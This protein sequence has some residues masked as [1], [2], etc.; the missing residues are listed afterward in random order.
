M[1]SQYISIDPAIRSGEP[2]LIGT[3]LT[4]RDVVSIFLSGEQ[5][6]YPDV[7]RAQMDACLVYYIGM[8]AV[9]RPPNQCTVNRARDD[10]AY[11]THC[12]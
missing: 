12:K 8:E 5:D 7:T 3:R 10:A 6:D 11:V 9:A 4:V 1:N 2:Y